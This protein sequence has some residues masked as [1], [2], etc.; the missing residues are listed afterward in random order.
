MDN[1]R[2]SRE[3]YFYRDTAP[4]NLAVAKPLRKPLRQNK[5]E[6]WQCVCVYPFSFEVAGLE[7]TLFGNKRQSKLS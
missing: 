5:E 7:S 1:L 6:N 2:E 4:P 3:R